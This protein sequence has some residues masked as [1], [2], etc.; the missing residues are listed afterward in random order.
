MDVSPRSCYGEL[1]TDL[2]ISIALGPYY[3]AHRVCDEEEVISRIQITVAVSVDVQGEGL[4]RQT[5]K[6][7]CLF[8]EQ[9]VLGY[10]VNKHTLGALFHGVRDYYQSMV[11]SRIS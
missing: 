2:G 6:Y 9:G 1:C 4:L 5:L 11:K 7:P 8:E 3:D 10:T